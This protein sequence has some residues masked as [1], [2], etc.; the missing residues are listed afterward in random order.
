MHCHIKYKRGILTVSER[1]GE[2][3]IID[4]TPSWTCNQ[5]HTQLEHTAACPSKSLQASSVIPLSIAQP[6]ALLCCQHN[7]H[8]LDARPPHLTL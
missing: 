2:Y 1:S 6:S 4:S 7:H 5:E 3:D 8:L